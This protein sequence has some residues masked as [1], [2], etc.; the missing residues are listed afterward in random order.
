MKGDHDD[1]S[2][3]Q[4][5]KTAHFSK[6]SING[7]EDYDNKVEKICRSSISNNSSSSVDHD[8]ENH[9]YQKNKACAAS[10]TSSTSSSSSSSSGS[11]RQYNRSK[12]PRLRWTPELH[13]CFVH[14]IQRL[15]GQERATPKLVLQFMNIKGLSISHVKSHLQMYRSKKIDDPDQ[16][17]FNQLAILQNFNRR[18][19]NSS[20]LIRYG[21]DDDQIFNGPDRAKHNK[22]MRT[23]QRQSRQASSSS[24]LLEHNNNRSA[25]CLK[26]SNNNNNCSSSPPGRD[27]N[28][29]GSLW[30]VTQDQVIGN[31]ELMKRKMIILES[32]ESDIDLNLSLKIKPNVDHHHHHDFEKGS[33]TS[34][35]EGDQHGSFL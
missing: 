29:N 11:T 18:P 10:F 2:C 23:H 15:G 34:D 9:D 21:D 31:I 5:S 30:K 8:Q 35:P 24:R 19:N 32:S 14:A 25:N 12:T 28:N 16:P 4:N 1:Y 6:E 22:K 20:C 7:C 13:L 17:D 33:E 26:N 27:D 3:D